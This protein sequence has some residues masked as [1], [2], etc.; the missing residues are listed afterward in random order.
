MSKTQYL[1]EVNPSVPEEL[2]RLSEIAD[3]LRYSWDRTTRDLYGLLNLRLWSKLNHSPKL[4]LRHVPQATLDRVAEDSAY[5]THLQ[6]V[7]A[8][9]DRYLDT[10]NQIHPSFKSTDLVAYFCAE[11]GMHESLQI[12]SGGLGI[13]AGDHCKTASD[14]NLPFVAVGLM[15]RQGYFRQMINGQGRQIVEN[16]E[17]RLEDLP[18][19]VAKNIHNE[20]II[21]FVEIQNRTVA[22]KVWEVKVGRIRLFLLDSDLPQNSKS[23]RKITY[24]LYAGGRDMRIQQEIVLGVGGVRALELL[25]MKPNVWHLNE[26]HA[27]FASL[28]RIRQEMA[29][30]NMDFSSATELVASNTVFTTHTPVPAGHDKFDRNMILDYLQQMRNAIGLDEDSFVNLGRW[31]KN[32]GEFNM[33]TLAMN[34]SRYQNGVSKLHGEVSSK[35]CSDQWK[36]IPPKENPLGFVTNGTHVPSFLSI[37]WMQLFDS[38]IGRDWRN[39]FSEPKLW[40]RINDF[41]DHEFWDIKQTAKTRLLVKLRKELTKQYTRNG[42]SE[43]RQQHALRWID[44]GNPSVLLIGFARRFATY[45]R[46]TLLFGNEERLRKLVNGHR[47][48]VFVFAGKAH[49]ADVPGQNL[50]REIHRISQKKDFLGKILIIENYD[51]SLSRR[52]VAG[53]DVWLNTPIYPLE[54]SGTSGMKAAINGTINLSILDGWWAEG[55]DGTNGWGVVGAHDPDIRDEEDRK[56]IFDLL[57]D[58]ILPLY[59]NWGTKAFSSDWVQVAKRSMTTILPKFN[60]AR[61]LTDYINNYY[62]PAREHGKKL[63]EHNG[64]NAR[65]LSEWKKHVRSAWSD[66]KI[67]KMETCPERISFGESITVEVAI[68]LNGLSVED[69]IAELVLLNDNEQEEYL[70]FQFVEMLNSTEAKFSTTLTPH[71]CGSLRYS[72]RLFPYNS[73][74]GHRFETG[75]MSW[76]S[77]NEHTNK[78]FEN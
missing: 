77:N 51:L 62:L 53:C 65:L 43:V 72:I 18:V 40:Q 21:V 16:V 20:E 66:V 76:I 13:L 11:F 69:L 19:S 41:E 35:L 42:M 75:L 74:L 10:S 25:G 60:M 4:T 45:K 23:D 29:A 1:L 5:L 44:P 36:Q 58:Q 38:H 12:Y 17:S 39:R 63:R 3:N 2:H 31:K 78:A 9:F 33:T 26:G 61:T 7:I 50:I 46:A 57:E 68:K 27:A 28:E 6:S 71:S 59:Y 56:A 67:W 22:L 47:P 34:G 32:Q 73:L 30:R 52:L 64:G 14:L 24:Q 37:E 55:F 54:A 70:Q 48:V 8:G 49:P 15:Y